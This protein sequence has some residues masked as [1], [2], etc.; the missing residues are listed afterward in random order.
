MKLL[1]S[2]VLAAW[3][4]APLV[5]LPKYFGAPAPLTNTRYASF[6][7]SGVL[8]TNGRDA[9]LLWG[10]PGRIT[11]LEKGENRVGRPIL[12][13]FPA[14]AAWTGTHFIAAGTRDGQH[15]DS[16]EGR[17]LDGTPIDSPLA[18]RAVVA[19]EGTRRSGEDD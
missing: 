3:S 1:L 9:F 10:L 19:M 13:S 12:N 18:F 16:I 5:A 11:R 8:V 14:A 4:A 15:T 7:G 17:L 6:G 2:W